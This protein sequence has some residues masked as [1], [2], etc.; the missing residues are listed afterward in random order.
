MTL[1]LCINTHY[2]FFVRIVDLRGNKKVSCRRDGARC[3]CRFVETS[4]CSLEVTQSH[5]KWYHS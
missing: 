5:W 4:K 1:H 2:I 3:D